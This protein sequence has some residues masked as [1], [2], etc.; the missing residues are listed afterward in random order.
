MASPAKNWRRYL[1]YWEAQPCSAVSYGRCW[2]THPI[3][4]PIVAANSRRCWHLPRPKRMKPA[5]SASQ[6]GGRRKLSGRQDDSASLLG[7][8]RKKTD[9]AEADAKRPRVEI[10]L[11]LDDRL[12]PL[13]SKPSAAA[14][15]EPQLL[16]FEFNHS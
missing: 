7:A 10:S 2:A 15:A 14:K 4:R 13:T 8:S 1:G 12:V 5:R 11:F 6:G 3:P 9:N 16:T